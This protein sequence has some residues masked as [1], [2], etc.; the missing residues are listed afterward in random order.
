MI[1][2]LSILL[3]C[4]QCYSVTAWIQPHRS[5]I[6]RVRTS[7]RQYAEDD[8]NLPMMGVDN[9]FLNSSIRN[10]QNND[11]VHIGG[12]FE[13]LSPLPVYEWADQDFDSDWMNFG[14]ICRGEECEQ[15]EIPDHFKDPTA[16]F[17]VLGFLGIQRAEPIEVDKRKP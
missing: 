12:L 6:L 10:Y 9:V 13:S 3:T 15:C 8:K 1:T 14:N 11:A 5:S 17:D 7:T 16:N 4:L 2:N